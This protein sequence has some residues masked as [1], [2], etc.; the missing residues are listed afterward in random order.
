LRFTPNCIRLNRSSPITNSPSSCTKVT[1]KKV[2]LVL[3][4]AW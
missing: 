4:M 2:T 1:M 3:P